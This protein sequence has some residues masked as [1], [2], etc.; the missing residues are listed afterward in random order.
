MA[1]TKN[2]Q[3]VNIQLKQSISFNTTEQPANANY[4]EGHEVLLGNYVSGVAKFILNG[5]KR[6]GKFVIELGRKRNYALKFHLPALGTS[7][8]Y[9]TYAKKNTAYNDGWEDYTNKVDTAFVNALIVWGNENRT[10]PVVQT[11]RTKTLHFMVQG[12]VSGQ[13]TEASDPVPF[14]IKFKYAIGG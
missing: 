13:N 3:P 14:R 10:V 5:V 12:I 6:K 9:V 11:F 4:A 7:T 8:M 2:L 1:L